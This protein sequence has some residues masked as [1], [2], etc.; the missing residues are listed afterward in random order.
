MLF[1]SEL[2]ELDR[3]RAEGLATLSGA[4]GE[5]E[6]LLVDAV[7]DLVGLLELFRFALCA[8]FLETLELPEVALGRLECDAAG[9]EEISRETASH[10]DHVS[11]CSET[12]NDL[13]AREDVVRLTIKANIKRSTS[14]QH[15]E[16][17]TDDR[18]E[19][20]NVPII[21]VT[22]PH[23]DDGAVST[24]DND[25]KNF[26]FQLKKSLKEKEAYLEKQILREKQRRG[27]VGST[28]SADSLNAIQIVQKKRIKQRK[29]QKS[30]MRKNKIKPKS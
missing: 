20:I 12:S 6:A 2:L 15:L 14:L 3:D 22:V 1:R 11:L 30:N 5:L 17:T 21:I 16:E 19:T 25:Y 18:R 4:Q 7:G 9:Q 23:E 24:W 8:G 13:E 29:R 26:K 10:L 28:G 27:S